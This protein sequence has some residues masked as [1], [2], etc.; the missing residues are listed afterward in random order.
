MKKSSNIVKQNVLPLLAALIWGTAFAAQAV[1]AEHL[2][3]FTVN[4]IRSAIAAVVLALTAWIFL[5][6]GQSQRPD[7]KALLLGGLLCGTLLAAASNLQQMG[8]SDT[9]AG[10]AGFLTALYVVLVPVFGVVLGKRAPA[11]VW[12]GA[13]IAV[14]G[15]YLLCVKAGERLTIEPADAALL[16]CAVI[17]AVHTHCVNH[18]A[19][20]VDGI[21]LSCAQFVVMTLL[22]AL[23]MLL[24]EQPTLSAVGACLPSLLYI[25]VFSSGVAYTLE[26]IAIKDADP[27]VVTILLSL[28][29]VFAVL[30]GALLLHEGLSAREYAGCALMFLA[31]LLAQLPLKRRQRA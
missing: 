3:P 12:L 18:F 27:T 28:E 21:Q 26:I 11:Q 10:K 7:W 25:G 13:V 6:L 9:G 14:A 31:V 2:Q 20:R 24:F 16:G 5:R 4:A 22:S 19:Q 8:I 17:F 29:S 23:G 1:A 15:L 30:A